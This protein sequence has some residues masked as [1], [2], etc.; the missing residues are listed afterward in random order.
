MINK[1]C[2]LHLREIIPNYNTLRK[3]IR[4]HNTF[5]EM[6]PKQNPIWEKIRSSPVVM[7]LEEKVF[8]LLSQY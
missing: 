7:I 4:N 3:T 1:L 6:N 8:L 5:F 2:Y